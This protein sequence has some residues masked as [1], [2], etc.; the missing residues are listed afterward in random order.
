MCCGQ[1]EASGFLRSFERLDADS[2]IAGTQETVEW[3]LLDIG[4]LDVLSPRT[5]PLMAAL[6]D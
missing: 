5:C 3:E 6:N 4:N 1:N 2:W